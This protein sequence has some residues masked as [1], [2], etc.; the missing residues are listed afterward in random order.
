MQGTVGKQYDMR[1]TWPC[2]VGAVAN[3][4]SLRHERV[5]GSSGLP[6]GA[7]P[8]DGGEVKNGNVKTVNG[9]NLGL[10][11]AGDTVTVANAVVTQADLAATNGVVH[12]IDRMLLPPK[13]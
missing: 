11:K 8:G 5:Q 10:A 3:A 7:R 6:P 9:A 1:V 2:A 12:I 4:S 13:R